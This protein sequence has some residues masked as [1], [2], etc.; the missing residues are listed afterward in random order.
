MRLSERD[1]KSIIS[2]FKKYFKEGDQLWLFGS[3]VD[4]ARKGGDIDL[5]IESSEVDR[6]C[7]LQKKV[8]FLSALKAAIGDQ[9]IDLVI[10][11]GGDEMSAICHEARETGVRLV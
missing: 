5:Y 1:L 3:R 10:K 2:I 7:L 8:S 6:T 4:H 9:K 11:A